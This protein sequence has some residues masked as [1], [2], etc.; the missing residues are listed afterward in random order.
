[1]KYMVVGGGSG[2]HLTPLIAVA[3]AL[4]Q[5]DNDAKVLYVGQKKEGLGEVVDHEAISD[6]Y[7]VSAGKFRRYHGETFLQHLLDV[8]TVLLNFRDFFRFV[9]GCFEAYFLLRKQ[10]PNAIFLKGGYVSVPIGFAAR[11]LGIPYITHDSDAVPGLA[12]RLTA[13]HARFNATAMPGKYY[14][15]PKEKN[16]HVGIPIRKEFQDYSSGAKNAARQKLGLQKDDLVLLCVGG[17][18]GARSVNSALS[19]AAPKLLSDH[20]NLHI[21]HMTGKKLFEETLSMYDDIKLTKQQKSRVMVKDFVTDLY[22]YSSAADLV[23]TRAGATS[24]A[25]FGSQKKLCIVVPNPLLTGG[26]QLHNA[27]V[28]EKSNAALILP[29]K[30]LDQLATYI[31]K[32]FLLSDSKKAA[33]TESFHGL[34]KQNAAAEIAKIMQDIAKDR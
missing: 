20:K 8:K 4:K 23:L 9:R 13:K 32:T 31:E 16:K 12:N 25:D 3:E 2:G 18:L 17:G 6:V 30:D 1:M 7:E 19:Q 11:L 28:L 21:L 24:I 14:P 26:Q 29:E 10:R 15:Y 33:I 34:T 27:A 22:V 5:L